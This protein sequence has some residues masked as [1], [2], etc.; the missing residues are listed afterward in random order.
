MKR[1]AS[2]FFY[3]GHTVIIDVDT[4]ELFLAKSDLSH[5][6]AYFL[7]LVMIIIIDKNTEKILELYSLIENIYVVYLLAVLMNFILL[8][9]IVSLLR[10]GQKGLE[11]FYPSGSFIRQKHDEAKRMYIK[12]MIGGAIAIAIAVHGTVRFIGTL[13]L[14]SLVEELIGMFFL[15]AILFNSG[16]LWKRKAIKKL[17]EQDKL[18]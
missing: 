17:F 13:S 6:V 15:G 4:G 9:I 5:T 2:I 3:N 12:G 7:A 10:S 11:P 18:E 1:T 16:M 14:M 8:L